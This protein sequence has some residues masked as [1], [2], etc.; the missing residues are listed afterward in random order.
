MKISIRKIGLASALVVFASGLMFGFDF[1]ESAGGIATALGGVVLD[2]DLGGLNALYNPTLIAAT[3][4]NAL[5]L[6]ADVCGAYQPYGVDGIN[7]CSAGVTYARSLGL[8]NAGA[9]L[10]FQSELAQGGLNTIRTYLCLSGDFASFSRLS[11]LLGFVDNVGASLNIKTVTYYLD[12][13]MTGTGITPTLVNFDLD[14]DVTASFINRMLEVGFMGSDLLAGEKGFTGAS[15]SNQRGLILHGMVQPI[16][17]LK[18]IAAYNFG[19]SS[20]VIDND[21]FVGSATAFANSYL[22]MEASFFDSIFVRV[23]LNEGRLTGGLG[24]DAAGFTLNIGVL[25]ISSLSL[26]YQIDLNYKFF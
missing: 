7:V 8:F 19:G 21:N 18:F 24:I 2:R 25:P 17:D 14:A 5:S 20:E 16:H 10:G 12:A 4:T 15:L 9:G 26:Y 3:L 22:G 23:G 1:Q 6:Q 11:D 13:N